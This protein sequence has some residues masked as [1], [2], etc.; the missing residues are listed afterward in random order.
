M[1][2]FKQYRKK[3]ISEMIPFK[4]FVGKDMSKI[5]VSEPDKQLSN[6]E[7]EQGYI[8]RNPDNHDD[9]W[10]VAKDYFDANYEP[11]L[12]VEQRPYNSGDRYES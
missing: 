1:N 12:T 4:D 10:Y 3:G 7:F 9:M 11:A 5:S 8:A 2:E 6:E